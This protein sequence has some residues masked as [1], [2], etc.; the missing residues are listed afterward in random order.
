MEN[1]GTI[2]SLK[3]DSIRVIKILDSETIVLN[4][5]FKDGIQR[6]ENFE[7]YSI[8]KNIKDPFTNEDLGTLDNIKEYVTAD[9]VLEKMC[10]CRSHCDIDNTTLSPP[11]KVLEIEAK[12]MTNDIERTKTIKIG[13]Y[14]RIVKKHFYY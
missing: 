3:K 4:I 6:K 13:D 2:K 14:A 12:Q 1:K 5:G 8:G 7:I 10:I 11:N 9:V